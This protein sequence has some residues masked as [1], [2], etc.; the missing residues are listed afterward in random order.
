MVGRAVAT[1]HPARPGTGHVAADDRPVLRQDQDIQF[2]RQ[3]GFDQGQLGIRPHCTCSLLHHSRTFRGRE[4][5]FAVDCLSPFLR[6]S[7]PWFLQPWFLD[8]NLTTDFR[9]QPHIDGSFLSKPTDYVPH[10]VDETRKPRIIVLD[11]KND[12]YMREKRGLDFVEA[13][14]DAGIRELLERGKSYAKVMEEEGQFETLRK[15]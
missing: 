3:G 13:L 7:P 14:S 11:W 2:H 4:V 8:G 1:L 10:K 12:P 6:A 15:K 9:N 5:F